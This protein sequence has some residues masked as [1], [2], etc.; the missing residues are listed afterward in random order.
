MIHQQITIKPQHHSTAAPQHRSTEIPQHCLLTIF[1]AIIVV[2][3]LLGNGYAAVKNVEIKKIAILPFDNLSDNPDAVSSIVP[4]VKKE[5]IERKGLQIV[6]SDI[7]EDYMRR[8]RIRYTDSMSRVTV[9]KLG[10]MLNID[11]I[12]IGSVDIFKGGD[13]SQV[14][15]SLRLL[16]TENGSIIWIDSLSYSAYDFVRLLGLGKINSVAELGRRVAEDLISKMDI[17]FAIEEKTIIPF[18]VEDVE[19]I[20]EVIRGREKVDISV[21]LV[22]IAGKPSKVI[23]GI[24]GQN[25]S[26]K[27]EEE[28]VYHGNFL[29]P[30]EEGES[31][32]QITAMDQDNNSFDFYAVANLVVD[33]TPPKIDI[34]LSNKIFSP[35]GDRIDDNIIFSPK[36]ERRDDI[37]RWSIAIRDADG[38]VV[39]GDDGI[40]V[41]PRRLIWRGR[42]NTGARAKDGIYIYEFVVIDKAGNQTFISDEIILDT[43]PPHVKIS[44]DI[45]EKEVIFNFNYD[46]DEKIDNWELKIY[47][48]RDQV[49]EVI[50]GDGNSDNFQ[51]IAYQSEEETISNMFYTYV[52]TDIAGNI[53]Y[54]NTLQPI[55]AE[56]KTKYPDKKGWT[57]DF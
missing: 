15:L 26:L 54:N 16:S 35:N 44:L 30:A 48:G 34:K 46:L 3:L 33:T 32:I 41:F 38:E 25:I 19:I 6:S 49:V 13:N 55:M 10:K 52:A 21:R 12:M 39:R 42:T 9:R 36:L 29:S 2:S 24:E 51:R 20:P 18:E 40:G 7:L 8:M 4:L 56:I 1:L 28:G 11:A 17:K 57:G 5:I 47:K 43:T 22:S 50:R 53:Y 27:E 14:G 45:R 31:S 37:D 23:M